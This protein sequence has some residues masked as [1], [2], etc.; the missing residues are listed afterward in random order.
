[1][2]ASEVDLVVGLVTPLHGV[3]TSIHSIGYASYLSRHFLLRGMDDEQEF[4][5]FE[6]EFK[7]ISARGARS[8]ST[9][10]A[11]RTRR[12]SASC[13]SGGTRSACSTTRIRSIIMNPA[14]D[15]QQ[16]EFSDY[17]KR[18]LD[19]GGRA[20]AGGARRAVPGERRP[21]AAGRGDAG[22]RRL[23]RGSG[24]AA[25]PGRERAGQRHGRAAAERRAAASSF[26]TP[27]SP[28]STR[29]SRRQRRPPRRGVEAARAGRRARA[30]AQG[31]RQHLAAHRRAGGRDRRADRAPTMR[32]AARARSPA[33]QKLAAEIESTRHR[34]ALPLDAAKFGVPPERE[35][36]YVA[37]YWATTQAD[38]RARHGG[39]AR[40]PRR[41]RDGV[42]RRARRRVLTC[43]LELKAKHAA[44]GVQ[45]VRGGARQ[46]QGRDARPLPA[47]ADRDSRA[48]RAG[49]RAAPAPGDPAR[50]VR[51]DRLARAGPLLPQPPRASR[52]LT[53]W[54][55]STRRCC[56]RRCPSD[57]VESATMPRAPQR[58]FWAGDDPLMVAYHDE[59]WGVPIHDDRRW[60]EK[61]T[62]D[63]AQAGLS[64]MTILRKRE[65]YR[66]AFRGFDAAAVARFGER[67]VARLMK[68]AGIVRNR[69][70][71][72]SAIGNARA[73]LALAAEHGS[74]D[75]WIWQFIGGRAARRQA[76]RP[77]RHARAHA[78]FRRAVEGAAPARLLV[79]RVDDRLRV[80]AG[81]GAGQRPHRW[82]AS[83][84]RRS[85]RS[86][87]G[88]AASARLQSAIDVPV[89]RWPRRAE[90]HVAR[91]QHRT[92]PRPRRAR[93]RP[94]ARRARRRAARSRRRS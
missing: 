55:T 27:T 80:H 50:P 44:A 42:S 86:W 74:F 15:P 92:A 32:R 51:P 18:I 79:R 68:D 76:P 30:R 23:G 12:S 82:A 22:R 43:D 67:D 21:A 88:E 63:G 24:A 89:A 91:S 53:A 25:G 36:A 39:G 57:R 28:R 37:G 1:M 3:A 17:E 41:A 81:G 34:I 54:R 77:R 13:T 4:R 47:R 2:T 78:A 59:E 62:L 31:R 26:P 45:A 20:A 19:A 83:A 5:A 65:G 49:R 35:P 10:S 85:R 16:A 46:V 40:A 87:P 70:K 93:A 73:L 56:R 94:S 75:A 29:R 60:Y 7:L 69:L 66:A 61:L 38:G 84:A 11:R 72:K 14:Y 9:R 33:A 8:A 90:Q 71:I 52:R 48:A 58:C 64:W 6:Q